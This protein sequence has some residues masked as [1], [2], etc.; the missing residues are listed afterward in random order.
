M[1]YLTENDR[2]LFRYLENS[3][4]G[5]ITISQAGMMLYPGDVNGYQYLRK[6]MKLL[7]ERGLLK[8]FTSD[9]TNEYIYY[10][11]LKDSK[12]KP[13]NHDVLVNNFYAKLIYYGAEVYQY[14]EKPIYCDS[15]G[16][17][18]IPDGFCIYK[19]NGKVKG[20]FIECNIGH[21]ADIDRYERLFIEGKIHEQYGNF[22]Y[23]VVLSEVDR[24][25][26]SDNFEIINLDLKCSTFIKDIL[27][28]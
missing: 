8:Y 10:K 12:K 20:C 27:T 13:N 18:T 15:V 25:H 3:K 11:D 6:R 14:K 9:V 16:K 4:S 7:H 1:G 19:W 23:V 5:G 24:Q 28:L 21:V 2:W 26:N 22:P 17:K